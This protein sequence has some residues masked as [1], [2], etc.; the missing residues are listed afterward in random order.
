MENEGR[1][2]L[3]GSLSSPFSVKMRAILRYRRLAH[4]WIL[5]T[6]EWREKT[7]H[8]R[9]P[10]IPKL[11]F[12]E[13]PADVWHVDSSPMAYTLEERH[14]TRSI[15][16]DDPAHAFLSHLLED[17]G[18]EW[19]TK[20]MFYYRWVEAD[21][22]GDT[23]YVSHLMLYP[24]VGPA[25]DEQLRKTAH[26]FRDWQVPLW[27]RAGIEPQNLPLIEDMFR[28]I[29]TAWD[30]V[31]TDQPFLFGAR[32]SLGDFGFYGQ[33]YQCFWNPASFEV[34]RACSKR[35]VPWLTMIDDASGIE[36]EWLAP[37]APLCA[38]VKELLGLA[39]AVYLPYLDATA[40]AIEAGQDRMRIEVLDGL[41]HE[42][43]PQGYHA[44]C[45]TVMRDKLAAMASADRAKVEALLDGTDAW[46]FLKP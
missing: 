10:I 32:P 28:R 1:Y 26:G 44:K 29:V 23:D 46:R 35:L 31:L 9:P 45:L 43:T 42:Q 7:K 15:L 13:E 30:H 37:D 20:M 18:D 16:P 6:E 17:F 36:G 25:S 12:P 14:R 22:G 38:G 39:G 3:I 27:P 34:M 4:D 8:V 11:H 19:G 40:K 41:V 2:Q 33:L 24:G 21:K 5:N